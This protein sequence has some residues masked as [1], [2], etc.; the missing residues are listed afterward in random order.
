MAYLRK[1]IF[2]YNLKEVLGE[3]STGVYTTIPTVTAIE[4]YLLDSELFEILNHS[5]V[6]QKK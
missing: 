4:K 3:Q 1:K 5:E 2:D 6:S